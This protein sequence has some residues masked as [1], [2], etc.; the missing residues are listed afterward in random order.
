M[1]KYTMRDGE[2]MHVTEIGRGEPVILIH[3]LGMDG[4]SW[5]PYAGTGML[6]KRFYI[7][8]LRGWGKSRDMTMQDEYYVGQMADDIHDLVI[9]IGAPK[10]AL[11]G[12][13]LGAA[14]G[15]EYFKRYGDDMI[16]RYL[17]IDFPS[18][19]VREDAPD[20]LP[21]QL[22]ETGEAMMA[23]AKYF[24]TSVPLSKL[25]KSYQHKHFSLLYGVLRNSLKLPWQRGIAMSIE[26]N[27]LMKTFLSQHSSQGCWHAT[28][29]SV[30]SFASGDY[31][32]R[33]TLPSINIPVTN[34]V[35][36][37]D[38][39]FPLAELKRVSDLLPNSKTIE[40]YHSGHLLMI[41]EIPKFTRVFR[42]FLAEGN[43]SAAYEFTSKPV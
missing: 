4:N 12:I 21:A 9:K 25:P 10:V 42:R 14:I 28:L 31:D 22:I 16:S 35:G 26:Y 40:F 27:P 18:H 15:L 6:N 19:L 43:G 36:T 3:G 29:R 33:E 30:E 34:V 2:Q 1:P 7:P 23:E 32:I 38:T 37:H 39:L 24:D 11:V 8:D 13:S 5:L 20:A 41:T 17:H